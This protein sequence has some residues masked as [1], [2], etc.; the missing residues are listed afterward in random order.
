MIAPRVFRWGQWGQWGRH[1]AARA[2][3]VP[4]NLK[5][6]GAVWARRQFVPTAPRPNKPWGQL[7][8]PPFLAVSAVPKQKTQ[9]EIDVGT[10]QQLAGRLGLSTPTRPAAPTLARGQIGDLIAANDLLIA[11]AQQQHG[12]HTAATASPEWHQDRDQ[13]I[14]HLMSCR[15]CYAPTGRH[16]PAGADLRATYDSIPLELYL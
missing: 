15:S 5:T 4:H 11:P 10:L 3:A 7:Q 14:G 12:Y 16:C 1:S 6:L 8:A 13:Y 9:K 2:D